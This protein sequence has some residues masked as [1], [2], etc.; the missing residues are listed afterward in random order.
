MKALLLIALLIGSSAQAQD[1]NAM[2]NMMQQM[3]Q[4]N[5]NQQQQ[6][7][8]RRDTE[9]NQGYR[10]KQRCVIRQIVP[11]TSWGPAQYETVCE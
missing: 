5:W 4:G 7:Q 3:N 6:V 2:Q 10:P 8:P 9:Y 11:E 1:W